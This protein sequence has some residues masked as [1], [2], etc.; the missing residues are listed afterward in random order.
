MK[1]REKR[2]FAIDFAKVLAIIL[3]ILFHVLY[4]IRHD[5]SLR[6]FGFFGVSLFFI[7][8][9]YL[10]AKNYPAYTSF[11]VDWFL[12]HVLRIIPLYYLALLSMI[13]LFGRQVYDGNVFL[14]VSAHAL[15]IDFLFPRFHYD[16][17]SPAWF[18]TPLIFLYAL[19]PYLNKY[20]KGQRGFLFTVFC[21]TVFTRYMEGTWTSFSPIFFIAEFCFGIAFCN[22]RKVEGL[23]YSLLLL[24]VN[25][26]MVLPFFVFALLVSFEWS[27]FARETILFIGSS[28]LA[29]FLFHESFIH[30]FLGNWSLFGVEPFFGIIILLGVMIIDLYVA[31][32]IELF[33]FS[34]DYFK[35]FRGSVLPKSKRKG[36]FNRIRFVIVSLCI[37]ILI[38]FIALRPSS[39]IGFAVFENQSD[40][41][42]S[43]IQVV[44]VSTDYLKEDGKCFVRVF[45]EV[46]N[47]KK[48]DV[49]NNSLVCYPLFLSRGDDE[50]SIEIDLGVI[51]AG[52]FKRFDY[53]KV[54]DCRKRVH[55][56]CEIVS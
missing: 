35:K 22:G 34:L 11:R 39:L 40:F 20:V 5:N 27:F 42:S 16:F 36:D 47:D 41:G 53:K 26:Y 7:V 9:G 21:F 14:N 45:G 49:L 10:L 8:S 31:Q 13:F 2:S 15:F 51:E 33:L 23:L 4:A 28:T 37:V 38:S 43:N 6:M 32:R 46:S 1:K 25:P 29:L 55:Y 3:V 56:M 24:F 30:V 50:A 19:F 18:L 52:S 54:I 44:F 12:R 17:I 48:S